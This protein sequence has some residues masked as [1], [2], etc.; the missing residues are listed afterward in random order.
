M[1]AP[2]VFHYCRMVK[3][4][5]QPE[6][7]S[8]SNE[9][10]SVLLKDTLSLV[11]VGKPSGNPVSIPVVTLILHKTVYCVWFRPSDLDGDL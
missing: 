5:M 4:Q 8:W 6:Q 11:A 3:V 2:L 9:R 1:P 10:L 7:H